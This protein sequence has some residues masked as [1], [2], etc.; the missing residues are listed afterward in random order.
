MRTEIP[1]VVLNPNTGAYIQ[2]AEVLVFDRVSG[3]SVP[4]YQTEGGGSTFSQPLV[5][6][7]Q[8]QV[9]GWLE[10]GAVRF[11]ISAS[12]FPLIHDWYDSAPARDGAIETG[13]LADSSVTTV[14][15]ADLSISSGKIQNNAITDVKIA[16]GS[17]GTSKILDS[18]ITGNKIQPGTIDASKLQAGILDFIFPIGNIAPTVRGTAP[19]NWALCIGQTLSNA[20]TNYPALWAA[21]DPAFKSGSDVILPDLRG[22]AIVGPDAMGGTD[23]GR[24]SGSQSLAATG[25][26]EKHTA[27]VSEMPVHS[28]SDGGHQ[29]NTNSLAIHS[30]VNT[31][32]WMVNTGPSLISGWYP[33]DHGAQSDTSFANIQNTGGGAAQNNM[34]PYQCLNWIIRVQ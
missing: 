4:V 11:D 25:G 1:L 32:H 15:L 8:G 33:G 16:D 22:R 17:I 26:E 13:W 2:G 24:L 14:K 9:S 19:L 20:S 23:A 29:H 10:R 5:T 30:P 34:Q 6:D 31:G 3:A 28:H 27:T 12:G 7:A 21:V 18:S